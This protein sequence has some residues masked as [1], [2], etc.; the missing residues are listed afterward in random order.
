MGK[1]RIWGCFIGDWEKDD[2]FN[3]TFTFNNFFVGGW[4]GR[5]FLSSGR[6]TWQNPWPFPLTSPKVP[7]SYMS[8]GAQTGVHWAYWSPCWGGGMQ[9]PQVHQFWPCQS[10]WSL[11]GHDGFPNYHERCPGPM[12]PILPKWD[13]HHKAV[14]KRR[15]GGK[16]QKAQSQ[17]QFPFWIQSTDPQ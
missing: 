13:S 4:K 6:P 9:K 7:I 5:P 8:K 2:G 16:L 10:I 12:L 3:E 11:G 15:T 17:P 1:A 14:P